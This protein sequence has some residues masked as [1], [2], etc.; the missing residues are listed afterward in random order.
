MHQKKKE[1]ICELSLPPRINKSRAGERGEEQ[2]KKGSAEQG[3]EREEQR[4]GVE[5][6]NE[7]EEQRKKGRKSKATEA[8]STKGKRRGEEGRTYLR[9]CCL[10]E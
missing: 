5:E 8:Q 9:R 6:G 3:N 2:R 4:I 1:H 7:G 10:A